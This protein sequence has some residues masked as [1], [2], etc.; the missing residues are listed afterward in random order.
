MLRLSNPLA[1]PNRQSRA[2]NT[3]PDEMLAIFPHDL[4]IPSIDSNIHGGEI[5]IFAF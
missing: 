4:S 5:G 2:K 3:F 1:L